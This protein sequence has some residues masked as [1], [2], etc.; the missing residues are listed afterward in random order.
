MMIYR[1]PLKELAQMISS[2]HPRPIILYDMAHVLGLAGPYYQEPFKEG[3]DIVTSS[4]HKT[5]FWIP[6][7]DH[8]Q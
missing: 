5:F 7:R 2:M 1:E 4:T 3:A 6:E 8:R